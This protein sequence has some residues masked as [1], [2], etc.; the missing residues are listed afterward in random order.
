VPATTSRPFRRIR[1]AL[2]A[3]TTD[4]PGSSE[5][6]LPPKSAKISQ[7]YDLYDVVNLPTLMAYAC[8]AQ[9]GAAIARATELGDRVL[10]VPVPERGDVLYDV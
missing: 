4:R 9:P 1:Y 8:D 2:S 3:R 10:P 7:E 6:E 5:V